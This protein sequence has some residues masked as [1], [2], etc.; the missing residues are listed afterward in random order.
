M[1]LSPLVSDCGEMMNTSCSKGAM[2]HVIG[3]AD[4]A[5]EYNRQCHDPCNCSH[6]WCYNMRLSALVVSNMSLSAL[7]V[8]QMTRLVV[9]A[10]LVLK[11]TLGLVVRGVNDILIYVD[12]IF[13]IT[14]IDI[15]IMSIFAKENKQTLFWHLF[16]YHAPYFMVVKSIVRTF[17]LDCCAMFQACA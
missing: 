2:Q 11:M 12:T 3:C 15:L 7:L 6:Q 1:R 4:S 5:T 16:W 9:S 14:F 17:L 13:G 10:L 8:L